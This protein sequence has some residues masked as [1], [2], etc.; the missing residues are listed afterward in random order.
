MNSLNELFC[1][2]S[3]QTKNK[4]TSTDKRDVFKVDIHSPCLHQ[5]SKY[6]SPFCSTSRQRWG[7][8]VDPR[9]WLGYLRRENTDMVTSQ[10][11]T[12][13]SRITHQPSPSYLTHMRDAKLTIFC[14][15]SCK[16]II[17][18][19]CQQCPIALGIEKDK[20]H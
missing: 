16:T 2:R 15:Y 8:C 13:H 19:C 18:T 10:L 12:V 14:P 1:Q 9:C 17:G 20:T 7:L 5:H 3:Q 11:P 4:P 6:N